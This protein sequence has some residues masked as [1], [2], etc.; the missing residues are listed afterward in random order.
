MRQALA[1]ARLAPARVDAVEAHGTGT[2]LGDPSRP[3]RCW[4]PA[5][6][7]ATNRCASGSI[8]SRHRSHTGRRGR[9]GHHQDARG[10][11]RRR[12]SG[13]ALR[14]RGRRRTS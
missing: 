12:A 1:S 2:R 4:P 14:G 5:A 8:K 6:R 3:T 9:R 13:D 11:A 7:T 10:D